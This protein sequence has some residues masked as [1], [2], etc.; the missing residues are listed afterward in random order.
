MANLHRGE[1]EAEIGG[2]R[3]R[4]VLTLGAL[5]EL[6]AA[7]GAD[8]LV[9]L[10]ERFGAGRLKARDLVRIIGAGLR[11]AGEA[12][13]DDEVPRMA[14]A[15]GAQGYVRIAAELIAATFGVADASALRRRRTSEDDAAVS[16]EARRSASASACC[17]CR[18]RF[19]RMTPRELALRDRGGERAQR[20]PLDRAR[21]CAQLMRGIPMTD[22]Y[23]QRQRCRGMM[24]AISRPTARRRARRAPTRLA[25]SANGF[26]PRD[27]AARSRRR[28]AGGKQFDDVLK[29][30]ALRL[31]SL[32]VTQALQAAGQR[33]HRRAQ[34]LFTGL[35][36]SGSGG[37]R[38][39]AAMG[40]IKPFAAGGVIGTPTYFP[41]RRRLGLAGEAGPEAIMPLAR[42]ADGRLGVAMSGGGAPANVTVQIATPDADSFRRSEAYLTGQ[43]ARAVA[44]G[45]R[46]SV[47][48][49]T[50]FHEVLFPLDIALKS[51]G[52]P[53]RR[54]E[55]V[56]LGSGARGAQ[57]A[58]GAFAP[59]LRRRLWRQDLRGAVAGGGVLRGAA[60]AALRLSL[61]RPARSFVGGAGR[62]VAPTDQAIGTGDGATASIPARARPTAR[63]TRPISGRSPSRWRAACASRSPASEAEEGAAFTCDTTTGVVTFLAGH[64]PAARR[65]DHRRLPVRRAGAFR[66]RLSRG[67]S[68]GLRRRRDPENPAGGDQALTRRIPFASKAEIWRNPNQA[69][70]FPV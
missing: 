48:P 49:M 11:G 51:A 22:D 24:P 9:A 45:Q 58:L 25:V 67:R 39:R 40:A 31:S 61:A 41:L 32:A 47:M 17:G 59:A 29:S 57:R 36:G 50:A 68:V 70:A 60:R 52:G 5:A 37:R 19:W 53:E 27:D 26:R 8:D 10:A 15:G 56:A 63:F 13:S 21:R 7:F 23:D 20:A 33:H 1:I 35:F 28:S 16:L 43:I 4:L 38:L 62:S 66:H 55:I 14:V 18:P 64:M 34:S 3:R 42:G 65:G 6:E 69:T 2:A 54:T 44:R 46:G 30:L 12:V